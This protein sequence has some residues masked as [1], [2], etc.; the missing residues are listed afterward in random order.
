MRIACARASDA[1]RDRDASAPLG[2]IGDESCFL[3]QTQG[4]K[5]VAA[6]ISDYN[7]GPFF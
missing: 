2:C 4:R 3:A 5:S 6:E 7:T 1:V